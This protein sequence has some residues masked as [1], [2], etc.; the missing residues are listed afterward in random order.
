MD[1]PYKISG[2]GIDSRESIE[3]CQKAYANIPIF[4]NAVD[5]MSEFSNSEIYLE[6][7]SET[8]RSFIY[9]WFEKINLWKLKDQFFREYYRSGNIFFYRIDG[10]FDNQDFKNLNKIYGSK[11]YL[12]P[13]SI[14]IRYILLKGLS[15]T[16]FSCTYISRCFRR[17]FRI[18]F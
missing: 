12:N 6:G 16:I 8:A 2:N 11:D 4:R 1:L 9:K 3:L 17:C 13:G 14:P 5:V 18:S 7:G 15:L 10:N